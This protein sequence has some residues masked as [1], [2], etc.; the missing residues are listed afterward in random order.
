MVATRRLGE[1]FAAVGARLDL[2]DPPW[3][4]ALSGGADSAALA[5]LTAQ[6]A[7]ARAVHVHHGLPAS[8]ALESAA[9]AVAGELSMPVEVRSVTLGAFSE[10]EA[11]N[12]RYHALSAATGEADWVLTAHTADDQAET[13][14]ANLLRGAGT[15]GLAGIPSRRD[16]IARPLLAVTRSETRELATVADLP[17][18]DDPSNADTRLLRNRIRLQLIPHL[19][20][21]FN[22]AVR[23]HLATAAR[24]IS[25]S[26]PTS[27]ERGEFVNG[28][29][30]IPAGVLWATG[31]DEAVRSMRTVVR[32][33]RDGYGLDRN[34]SERVWRVVQG[35]VKAAEL[36]GGLRVS[37]SGPWLQISRV[38]LSPGR[39]VDVEDS[40]DPT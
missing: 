34:E 16:N 18:I 30:R 36:T 10:N 17:W 5:W 3:V 32:R 37:R 40:D 38:E 26:N 22:P 11:R 12:A 14:L 4:V 13:V 33:L 28:G 35:A 39:G 24:A 20:A 1:L 9:R 21:E 2:P 23:K 31:P 15:D 29:W 6:V 27:R 7:P 8:D 19:E 25:E